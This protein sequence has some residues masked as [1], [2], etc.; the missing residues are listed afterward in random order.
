MRICSAVNTWSE[1]G[2]GGGLS[3]SGLSAGQVV[4]GG[5]T[6]SSVAGSGKSAPTGAFVGDSDVQTLSNKTL[7]AGVFSGA[8]T[9]TLDLRAASA[10]FPP[11]AAGDPAACAAGQQ[12][13]NSAAQAMRICVS[14][15]T[16]GN[17]VAIP[18]QTGEIAARFWSDGLAD[19]KKV[20]MRLSSACTIT[21]WTVWSD[22]T[23][24]VEFDIHRASYAEFPNM[25]SLVGAGTKPGIAAARKGAGTDLSGWSATTLAAGDFIEVA[26]SGAPGGSATEANLTLK[27]VR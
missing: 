1:T 23:G 2:T 27:C 13:Y 20:Q 17:L 18:P 21:E 9:G 16:W 5:A 25:T 22:A 11:A 4:V 8:G 14:P 7:E 10:W 24:T 12:Y 19:G 6:G 15:N 3:G 26:V